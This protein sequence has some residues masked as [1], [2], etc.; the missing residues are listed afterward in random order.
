VIISCFSL[1]GC[2]VIPLDYYK[3]YSR[4]NVTEEPPA[5]IV[6][7][8]TTREEVLMRLGEPDRASQDE[9]EPWY[10]ASKVKGGIIV[11]DRGGE[12]RIDYIYA[13]GFDKNGL[14]ETTRLL[15]ADSIEENEFWS[16]E[17]GMRNFE[18]SYKPEPHFSNPSIILPA[19]RE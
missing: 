9:S 13:I 12:I 2:L 11:G 18:L 15:K 5:G 14:V 3:D 16:N 4:E 19:R 10:M 7:G 8:T 6:S 1:A 17:F